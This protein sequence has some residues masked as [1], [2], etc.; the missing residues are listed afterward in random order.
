MTNA[1]FS[2]ANQKKEGRDCYAIHNSRQPKLQTVWNQIHEKLRHP[3]AVALCLVCE[4]VRMQEENAAN[5][6][7]IHAAE[8]SPSVTH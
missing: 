3:E 7:I 1:I 8:T 5:D 2:L 4:N 6:G